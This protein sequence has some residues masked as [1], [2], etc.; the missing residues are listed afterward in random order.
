MEKGGLGT[1]RSVQERFAARRNEFDQ[2]NRLIVLKKRAL[3]TP[4]TKVMPE[5]A[6]AF[7]SAF[8]A[9]LRGQENPTFRRA[10]LRSCWVIVGKDAIRISGPKSVLAHQLTAEKPL[11]PSLVDRI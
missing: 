9:H 10:Y 5:K 7:A 11:P 3:E 2:I 6:Q 1:V 4:I 8:R